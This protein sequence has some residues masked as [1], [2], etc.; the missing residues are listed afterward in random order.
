MDIIKEDIAELDAQEKEEAKKAPK[1]PPE[2]Q[3]W[4]ERFIAKMNRAIKII[5]IIRNDLSDF[6]KVEAEIRKEEK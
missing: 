2:E 5:R 6:D 4:Q 1:V 3:T